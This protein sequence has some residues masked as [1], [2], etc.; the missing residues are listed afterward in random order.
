MTDSELNEIGKRL[1]KASKGPWKSMM[2]G[3]DH[4]SGDGFIMTGIKEG[5]DI[6]SEN[7][8]TD[9]YLTGA[10]DSDQDFIANARQD[11]SKLLTEIKRLKSK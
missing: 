1:S 4:T 10:T 9:I 8:G 3:R 5:E 7:R 2:E 6:W 11:I